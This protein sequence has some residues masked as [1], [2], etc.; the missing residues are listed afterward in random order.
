VTTP[1]APAAPATDWIGMNP[2]ARLLAL[3]DAAEL[4]DCNVVV[5]E[6]RR[7]GAAA[8]L[9]DWAATRQLPVHIRTLH[10]QQI[11]VLSVEMSR[12]DLIEVY[13]RTDDTAAAEAVAE[14]AA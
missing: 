14:R 13:V 4:G 11:V 1:Y 2:R 6:H 3:Y 12:Q 7:P 8:A 5:W 10:D 9:R